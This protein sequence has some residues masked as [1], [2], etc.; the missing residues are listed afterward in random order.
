M[1]SMFSVWPYP[2][3]VQEFPNRSNLQGELETLLADAT[4]LRDSLRWQ[5]SD[6]AGHS[7]ELRQEIFNAIAKTLRRHRPD[8]K[9]SRGV[10]DREL[11]RRVG[12][13][14]D[15]M[16]LIFHKVTGVE[17]NLDRLIRG[18]IALPS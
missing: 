13:Y 7:Q 1:Q 16:R 8:L 10:Y 15:A 4:Q 3:T 17:E 5:Q 2:L 6:D 18:E 9:P 14:A 12:V 11:R